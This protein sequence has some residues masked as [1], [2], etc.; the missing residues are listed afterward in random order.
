MVVFLSFG[1]YILKPNLIYNRINF[2]CT[3][4]AAIG[5]SLELTSNALTKLRSENLWKLRTAIINC[6]LRLQLI[7]CHKKEL[8]SSLS[9]IKLVLIPKKCY[10]CKLVC[11]GTLN[12]WCK[13]LTIKT[14]TEVNRT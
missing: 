13:I 5:K 11:T 7:I 8:H 10:Q 14:L 6:S 4:E 3:N 1:S 12:E 2:K 9:S